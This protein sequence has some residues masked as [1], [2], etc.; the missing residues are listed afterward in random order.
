MTE[1][2]LDEIRLVG[3]RA[4][5]RHGVYAHE[6][7]AGQE[8]VADVVIH[9]D[10]RDVRDDVAR[11]VHYGEVAED[12]A[13]VLGGW[14]ADLIETVATRIAVA[15][16][17][18]PAVRAV[19]VTV[20]KPQAPIAVPFD[21]VQVRLRRGR[22]E[23]PRLT[24]EVVLALGANLGTPLTTLREAVAALRRHPELDVVAVS[25]LAR[26]AAV[27]AP[28]QDLQP[29]YLNAV[30][31]ARTALPPRAVLAVARELE[32]AH[33]RERGERWGPRTLDVDVVAH[34][35]HVSADRELTLPHPRAH[36]RAFVLIPWA[37]ADPTAEL[38]G[39]GRV[40]DLAERV[41]R[42]GVRWLDP[43]WLTRDPGDL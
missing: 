34:G 15:V 14:P 38:P 32:E 33:G 27:L 42:A 7:D 37:A 19:E 31:V 2:G 6:R 18:R 23:L 35:A 26:T 25:P 40:A 3:V 39:H 9:L 36:E 24:S 16:L 22:D 43:D 20:H 13:A 12:V 29:D 11:T 8:F 30:V 28:G 4:R 21:D 5:G 1:R 41:E 10:L 17:A